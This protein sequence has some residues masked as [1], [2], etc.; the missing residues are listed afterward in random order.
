MQYRIIDGVTIAASTNYQGSLR[1]ADI[2]RLAFIFTQTDNANSCTFAEMALIKI[3]ITLRKYINGVPIDTLICEGARLSDLML[4]TNFRGGMMQ[5]TGTNNPTSAH[6]FIDVGR[7]NLNTN[8][9]LLVTVSVGA[10]GALTAPVFYVYGYKTHS[11]STPIKRYVSY[12]CQSDVTYHRCLEMYTR[13]VNDAGAAGNVIYVT[14][15]GQQIAVND[16]VAQWATM[17]MGGFEDGA[18]VTAFALI[19]MDPQGRGRDVKV[20]TVANTCIIAVLYA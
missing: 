12:L 9:E 18:S 8:D 3:N 7:I 17:A 1:A 16:T 5:V 2:D 6:A 14:A 19:Y 20:K 11:I 4:L 13:G 10:V 15:A